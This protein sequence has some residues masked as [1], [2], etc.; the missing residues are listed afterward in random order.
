M[1]NKHKNFFRH[2]GTQKG[3]NLCSKYTK[4]R[5]KVGLCPGPLGELKRSARLLIAPMDGSYF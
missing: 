2:L 1:E 4:I 3:A 5:L